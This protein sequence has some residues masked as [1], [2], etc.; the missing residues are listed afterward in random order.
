MI[1]GYRNLWILQFETPYDAA[2]AHEYYS[3]LGCVEYVQPDRPVAMQSTDD[4]TEEQKSWSGEMTR[5][6]EVNSWLDAVS[7]YE[8]KVG[9]IDSGIDYNNDVFEGRLVDNGVNLSQSGDDT[10][11][12][13]DPKSHGTHIAGIIAMNTP[14]ATKLRGYKIFDY[15]GNSTEL[16]V[17]TAIDY[18]VSDGMD[19]I[20]LSLGTADSDALRESLENAY[21]SGMVIV[22]ASGN[23]GINCEDILPAA[24][25]GSITVGAVDKNGVPAVFSN[26]GTCLDLIAPGVDIYS[27]LNGNEYGL[28]SGTSMATPFVSA[29]S[30]LMLSH[31]SDLTPLQIENALKENALPVNGVYSKAKTGSG[32][33]NIAEAMECPRAENAEISLSDENI[34]TVTVS[35]SEPENTD[36]YYTSDGTYP[37]PENGTLYDQPFEITQSCEII[38]RSF[39]ESKNLFASRISSEKI[40]IYSQS[41]ESLFTVDENGNLTGYSG[42]D[43]YVKVPETVNGITVV[44]VGNGTFENKKGSFRE[45]ILPDTVKSIGEEAFRLNKSI[46]YVK[47]S[48]LETVGESAFSGCSSLIT[49]D[50]PN[51]KT[52]SD[53]AFNRC[54]SLTDFN[55]SGVTDIGDYAFAN[56]EGITQLNLDKLENLG[57]WAFSG[58]TYLRSFRAPVLKN[59]ST[60]A[61]TECSS[62]NDISVESAETIGAQ[63]FAECKNLRKL[64]LPNVIT[65]EEKAF[66][67]SGIEHI[68][69]EKLETCKAYFTENCSVVLPATAVSLG[70][71]SVYITP[72]IHL[73]I[74][75]SSGTYA[76][77]W[78]KSLH[79][80]CTSE[81]IALPAVIT[82]FPEYLT[83]Q[84][85]ISIDATGFNLTYQW[86]GSLDGTN[87][88]LVLLDGE[89]EKCFN[90]P[91]S[92]TYAGYFCTVTSTENGISSSVTKGAVYLSMIPADYSAYNSAK[93]K[94][95]SDLSIYTDESASALNAAL[96][97]DVSGKTADKQSVIDAQTQ[98]ILNAVSLLRLKPADYTAVHAAIGNIPKDLSPY[99]PDSVETLQTAVDNVVYTH[100]ITMQSTVDGYAESINRAIESLEKESFFARLFRKI[101]EFFENLFSF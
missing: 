56:V 37:T 22:T 51:L 60:A 13:D 94:V 100:D 61:L 49:V 14:E 101:K 31:D 89:T 69:F 41:D 90:I 70:F 78:A 46:E 36:I 52:I 83:D 58:N 44:A 96:A 84:N 55:Q 12:S 9:I 23:A 35:F 66:S 73:K 19:I 4:F 72:K 92:K 85:R 68:R 30:A 54:T 7:P 33:L 27:C 79:N 29:A 48:G 40:S 63:A 39:S 67:K 53:Y 42:T 62:L 91:V 20:N 17:I 86:Y 75:A 65:V 74:F 43:I 64:Y 82:D 26:Y 47:A 97:V 80:N 57:S 11:M 16:L 25:D 95:P 81:F 8:V 45:I 5:T 32:I 99:T 21:E 93:A 2:K 28:V 59:I 87:N 38:W 71:D 1:S 77:K 98:A 6:A 10:A 24:F 88:N 15:K 3:S 34:G 76:E 18:A 50:A